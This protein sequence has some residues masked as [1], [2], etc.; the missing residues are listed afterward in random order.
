V[1]L[2]KARPG[3]G[4]GV[5]SGRAR[6]QYLLLR[7]SPVACSFAKLDLNGLV[8]LVFVRLASCV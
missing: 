4:I 7:G 1:W 8:D 2:G 6:F 3:L 5:G